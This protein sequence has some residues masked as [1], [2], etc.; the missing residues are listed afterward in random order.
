MKLWKVVEYPPAMVTRETNKKLSLTGDRG[1][2]CSFFLIFKTNSPTSREGRSMTLWE[3][4][5]YTRMT[6][7][8]EH[9]FIISIHGWPGAQTRFPLIWAI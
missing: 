2:K 3:I 7:I 8:G 6:I 4:A 1:P 5:E 9:Q